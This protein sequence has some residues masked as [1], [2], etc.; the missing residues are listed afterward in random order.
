M[1][2]HTGSAVASV[3]KDLAAQPHLPSTVKNQLGRRRK[4][5]T[6]IQWNVRTLLDR[7]AADRQ[8]RNTAL[9]ANELAKCNIDIAALCETRLSEFGSIN[10]LEYSFSGVANP[11]EKEGRPECGLLSKLIEMLSKDNFATIISVYAPTMTNPDETRRPSTTS[12][13]VYSVASLVQISYC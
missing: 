8:E 2:H 10:D 12:W 1:K 11:K 9:V 7:E 5:L 13:Q 6:I 4:L 3:T